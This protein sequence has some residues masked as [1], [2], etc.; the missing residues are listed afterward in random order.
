MR[1]RP[2]QGF[3]AFALFGVT[4]LLLTTFSGVSPGAPILPGHFPQALVGLPPPGERPKEVPTTSQRS[5]FGTFQLPHLSCSGGLN[6]TCPHLVPSISVAPGTL[7][8]D[9]DTGC[10]GNPPTDTI[11]TL[12]VTARG[13]SQVHPVTNVQVVFVV[14]T[15]LFDGVYDKA[16][17]DSGTSKC[18]GPCGESVAVPY[19]VANA[20]TIAQKIAARY[21]G[22]SV[23]FAM[24]DYFSTSDTL[25]GPGCAPDDD[26]DGSEYNVDVA[27]FVPA[28]QFQAAVAGSFQATVLG[29]G[30]VY[31]DSDFSDNIGDSSVITALYGALHGTG[32]AWNGAYSHAIVLISST[33][34]RDPSYPFDLNVTDSDHNALTTLPTCEP[35]YVYS[36]GTVSPACE[37]WV[38]GATSIATLAR[39]ENVAIDT[40]TLPDGMTNTSMGDYMVVNASG[41]SRADVGVSSDRPGCRGTP[42][43]RPSSPG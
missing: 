16:S 12:N 24:V 2:P 42:S 29:G 22:S 38:T 9:N 35:S 17:G 13:N 33:V 5:P 8:Q 25:S 34:P 21:P 19:F 32:L 36:T 1:R 14:E 10:P 4:V 23:G 15:T 37:R 27:N 40:I 30:Y 39:S 18:G 6:G 7:C 11:V 3:G 28:S 26:C 41:A 43:L 31:G 20:G